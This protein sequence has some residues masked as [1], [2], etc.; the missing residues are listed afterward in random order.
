MRELLQ[1]WTESSIILTSDVVIAVFW[2]LSQLVV[3]F[4]S[5]LSHCCCHDVPCGNDCAQ[6][7][8]VE[9]IR[10]FQACLVENPSVQV[11]CFENHAEWRFCLAPF[12]CRALLAHWR[13]VGAVALGWRSG[14]RACCPFLWFSPCVHARFCWTFI[15]THATAL[16]PSHS[17]KSFPLHHLQHQKKGQSGGTKSPKRGPFPSW[18]TDRSLD[19]RVLPGHKSQ[20]FC[21]DLC[22]P[23]HYQ[24]SKWRYSGIRLKVGRNLIVYDEN[25]TWW[26]LGRIVQTMNTRVWKTQDRSGIVWPGESYKKIGSDY[27]RLNTMVKRSI[28]QD[29]RNKNLDTRNGNYEKRR[30]QESGDKTACTKN[31][32]RLLAMESQ[33]Q[34]SNGDTCSFRHDIK[35]RAKMTQLSPSPNSFMQQSERNASRTRSHRGKSPSGRMSRWPCKD[36]LKGTC[37]NSFCEEW[38]LSRMLVLQDQERLQIW[39]KVLLCTSSGWWTAWQ[40]VR[41]RMVTKMQ[42]PCRRSI[43]L[44]VEHGNLLSTV[45]KVMKERGNAL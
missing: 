35:K 40:K 9:E 24:S 34:C 23:V 31:S 15:L 21:R 18:K 8:S 20:R 3:F 6:N 16:K 2:T 26:H 27:Q 44:T 13:L 45:T 28:E 29:I 36:Y 4:F 41:K 12:V 43:T 25:S 33:R 42:W 22:R 17:N 39:T 19:L 32:W 5:S 37:T 30:G 10:V 7:F 1:H 38:H 14:A 11:V